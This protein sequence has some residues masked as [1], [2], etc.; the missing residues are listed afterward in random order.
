MTRLADIYR[1]DA[2]Y[3]QSQHEAQRRVAASDEYMRKLRYQMMFDR[4]NERSETDSAR[5]GVTGY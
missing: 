2:K 1:E 3:V 5:N 4:F